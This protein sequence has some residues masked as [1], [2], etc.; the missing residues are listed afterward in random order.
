MAFF[1]KEVTKT[2]TEVT[3]SVRNLMDEECPW[4]YS[5]Y[6]DKQFREGV[7]HSIMGISSYGDPYIPRYPL[8]A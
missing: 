8:W 4:I 3:T 6:A 5:Y 2:G 7:S 1:N